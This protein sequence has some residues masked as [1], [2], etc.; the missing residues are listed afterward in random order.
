MSASSTSIVMGKWGCNRCAASGSATNAVVV[1][2]RH[3]RAKGHPT[4]AEETR[5]L[6]FGGE[7]AGGNNKQ[8]SML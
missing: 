8:G 7:A 1:A 6:E 2:A 4:W 3:S 5:R